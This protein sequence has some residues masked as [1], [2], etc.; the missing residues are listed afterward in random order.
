MITLSLNLDTDILSFKL[1]RNLQ[2]ISLC[3]IQ[4]VG[5]IG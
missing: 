1:T 5:V 4:D 3:T 2:L